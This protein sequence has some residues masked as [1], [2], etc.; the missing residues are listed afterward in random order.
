[1]RER[2][3]S[4]SVLDGVR[5]D[6]GRLRARAPAS[7]RVKLEQHADALREIEK[8]LAH[9]ERACAAPPAPPSFPRH[10]AGGGGEPYFDAI[11]DLQID[12]LARALGCDLTRFATL[13]LAN[14][15][16]TG[17]V[18]ELPEDVHGE[19]A[20]L[21]DARTP[22]H[23]GSPASWHKL[24]LQNRYGY[25]KVARLLQ[26]LDEA[27]ALDTTLVHASSDMGDPARHSSRNVPT[28]LAGGRDV[29][30]RFGRFV[31]LHRGE[32]L[33]EG[34]P[35]NRLLVSIC[36]LF[37]VETD[38]FGHARDPEVVAGRLAEVF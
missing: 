9:V 32:R 16:R 14:L 13:Y 31:D 12:L 11:T 28:L 23:P 29:K 36:Q 34:V 1:M 37:G 24:A 6:L 10:R 25:G 20:H 19:V 7:E 18:A 5:A 22:S 4:K 30:L 38:R 26:R 27:G 8:R 15:T 17:L 35:N 21:Y 33:Q 2:R 3:L